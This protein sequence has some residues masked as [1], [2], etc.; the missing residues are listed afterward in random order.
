MRLTIIKED[1]FVSVDNEGY[2][3]IDLSTIN[4]NIHAI[5]WY[6]IYGDVE[7]KNE[8]GQ[9]VENKQITNIDEYLF[10]ISLW[11]AEKDKFTML[12]LENENRTK[13]KLPTS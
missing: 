5:Q 6:E 12:K 2:S 1:G 9:I 3:G 7:I 11:Q 8:K 13:I 10:V 4:D